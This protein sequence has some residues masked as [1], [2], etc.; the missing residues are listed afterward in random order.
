MAVRL[1]HGSIS[2][3]DQQHLGTC[4]I[5]KFSAPPQTSRGWSPAEVQQGLRRRP[6]RQR[7][8]G[9]S[10]L[11][12]GRVD[13]LGCIVLRGEC[14]PVHCGTLSGIPELHPLGA[15]SILAAVTRNVPR[16]CQTSPGGHIIH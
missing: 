7:P 15:K 2:S 14:C 11:H 8:C 12:P 6:R 10:G 4:W 9:R 16:R 5:C 1:A 13:A 3:R